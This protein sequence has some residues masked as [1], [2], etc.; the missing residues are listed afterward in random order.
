M[1]SL[2]ILTLTLIFSLQVH[3]QKLVLE[4]ENLKVV[5][6]KKNG[7]IEQLISKQSNWHIENRKELGLSF[8]MNIP[9]PNQRFNPV[10]GTKQNDVEYI[11]DNKEKKITFVW[12]KI[13]SENGGE[14]PITFKGIAQLTEGGLTFT[15]E[16]INK[17]D[18]II[19]TI[20]WPQLGDLSIPDK[21]KSFS[22]KGIYYGGMKEF[23]LYPKF[24]NEPGYFAVDNPSNW[25]E[26]PYTSFVLLGNDNE[27]LYVGY[28]D[29]TARDLLQFKSEMKPGFESYELWDTG[30]NPKTDSIAGKVVHYEFYTTHF[31]FVKP[32]E[33]LTLNPIIMQPYSGGWNKGADIYKKWRATWFKAPPSPKWFKEVNSWQQIHMN[34]PEDDIRYTY[35]DLLEIGKDCAANGVKAIQVTGWTKGGQDSGNP[36][37]DIDPRLGTWQELKDVIAE[38]QKL[39]VKIILFT[40][41][42]WADRTTDWY[43]NDLIK[44]ATK[45]PYGYPHYYGGY[46][47]QTDTQLADIN[48]HR[49][50]PMCHLSADWRKIADKEFMKTLDLGADGMLFDENQHHG[51]AK[52]CFDETHGHKVPAYIFAGDETLA[53]GFESIKNKI[54]PD[55]IF[56]G[57]GHYDLENRQYHLSYFRVDLNHVPIQ[58][59]VAPDEEMQIAI[60]GYND[61]NLVNTALLYRYSISYEPRNFKGRLNEFPMTVAYGNKMDALRKKYENFLWKGTF[62][63]VVGADV[64][65]NKVTYDK[66]AVF[67][68]KTSGKK[69]V[70]IANFNYENAID[71]S[72]NFENSNASMSLVSPEKPEKVSFNGKASIPPNSV[73]VVFEN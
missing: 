26:F 52:Y 33:T 51:D 13:R 8:Y 43:K 41:F 44:Y 57:E 54:N 53:K 3:A 50:S 66:Y 24:Q 5:F 64:K 7:S 63:H 36:S 59:Y 2:I 35:K 31:P 34:N 23:N 55:Y 9:L 29:T 1:K 42:T 18:H 22:Q 61:R 17:S 25:M 4:N 49:F 16:I 58:R 48:T 72:L 40:K 45:D 37:H 60:S 70:V 21:E 32:N 20:R 38:V 10:Y 19:E 62:Q 71:I 67:T 39:G 65:V 69:A 73:I 12:N 27:G 6:N 68:D 46:A 28:H 11:V 14:L 30:V 15:G 47:Y 56:A